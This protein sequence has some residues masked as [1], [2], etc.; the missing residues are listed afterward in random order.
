MKIPTTHGVCVRQL[1]IK[2]KQKKFSIH[3]RIFIIKPIIKTI[4]FHIYTKKKYRFKS[5]KKSREKLIFDKKR[6]QTML[7]K[8]KSNTPILTRINLHG[9][10]ICEFHYTKKYKLFS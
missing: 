2:F 10:H 9:K 7:Y 3:T 5:K 4:Y 1:I 8:P 6:G